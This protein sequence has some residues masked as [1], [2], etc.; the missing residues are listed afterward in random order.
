MIRGSDTW[1]WYTL[2]L[3]KVFSMADRQTWISRQ[4]SKNNSATTSK[5]AV[6][7]RKRD[8]VRLGSILTVM[9]DIIFGE[10]PSQPA[11]WRKRKNLSVR[12]P[13]ITKNL[14]QRFKLSLECPIKRTKAS[15]NV[16][17]WSHET[18]RRTPQYT[19]Y[20]L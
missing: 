9:T 15:P 13:R 14:S 12:I 11:K 19:Q 5:H 17:D 16:Q 8:V 18:Q 2:R 3:F 1:F 10:Q 6:H 7:Y 20:E 4:R